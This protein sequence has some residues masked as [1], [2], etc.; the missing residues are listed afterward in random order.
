MATRCNKAGGYVLRSPGHAQSRTGA[1]LPSRARVAS[2]SSAG[3]ATDRCGIARDVG[4]GTMPVLG[5]IVEPAGVPTQH[6]VD[7][8]AAWRLDQRRDLQAEWVCLRTYER[9]RS[10]VQHANARLTVHA[11][12]R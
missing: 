9:R 8:E 6:V 10:L 1:S 12:R 3:A 11:R 2:R 7:G 5:A 4:Y